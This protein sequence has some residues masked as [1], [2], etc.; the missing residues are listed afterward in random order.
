MRKQAP[1]GSSESPEQPGHGRTI[2]ARP[3]KMPQ[4]AGRVSFKRF[5]DP[6]V[7]SSRLMI[8][9]LTKP[10]MKG[11]VNPKGPGNTRPVVHTTKYSSKNLH[12]G[13][14]G[15]CLLKGWNP[16]KGLF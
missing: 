1:V 7:F 6:R 14:T 3:I 15:A 4:L 5:R 9:E 16:L 12:C 8:P 10:W 2:P 11:Q 13:S